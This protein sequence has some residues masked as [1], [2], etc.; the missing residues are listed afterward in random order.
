MG[1]QEA[2]TIDVEQPSGSKEPATMAAQVDLPSVEMVLSTLERMGKR[3]TEDDAP[4]VSTVG[5][6]QPIPRHRGWRWKQS[7]QG[8]LSSWVA[9]CKA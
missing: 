3:R 8:R 2:P 5:V 7:R 9:H 1:T 6:A 4:M